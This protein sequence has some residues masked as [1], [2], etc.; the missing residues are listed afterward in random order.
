MYR[1]MKTND[2]KIEH[3]S[4]IRIR[5]QGKACDD[6]KAEHTGRMYSVAGVGPP[7]SDRVVS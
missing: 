4:K 3:I 1:E 7:D 5:V 6:E 2:D